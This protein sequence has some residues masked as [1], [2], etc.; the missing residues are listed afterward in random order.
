MATMK[1]D[2]WADKFKFKDGHLVTHRIHIKKFT[3][4]GIVMANNDL[5]P[6]EQD[7]KVRRRLLKLAVYSVPAIAT[8]MAA[9]DSNAQSQPWPKRLNPGQQKQSIKGLS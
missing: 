5:N 4:G 2:T 9:K 6:E 3:E 1:A 7:L 8:F